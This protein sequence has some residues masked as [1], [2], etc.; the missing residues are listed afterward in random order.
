MRH[1]YWEILQGKVETI[2]KTVTAIRKPAE[3][4]NRKTESN[5]LQNSADTAVQE[6]DGRIYVQ[7]TFRETVRLPEVTVE[8]NPPIPK[9]QEINWLSTLLP[10]ITTISISIVMAV[11]MGNTR[12]IIYTLPMT[13]VGLLLTVINYGN[14]KK[15]FRKTEAEA[16]GYLEDTE[17]KLKQ[18]QRKQRQILQEYNPKPEDCMRMV[19]GRRMES[20]WVRQ[21]KDPDFG[22]AKI[23]RGTI[24]GSYSVTVTGSESM[25]E[26]NLL[27][28]KARELKKKYSQVPEAPVICNFF[29]PFVCGIAGSRKSTDKFLHNVLIQLSASHCYT[30]LQVVVIGAQAHAD[31]FSWT[32]DLPHTQDGSLVSLK[33]ESTDNLQQLLSEYLKERAS[34]LQEKKSYGSNPVI[35]PRYLVVLLDPALLRKEYELSKYLFREELGVGVLVATEQR[36]LLLPECQQ[37]IQLEGD[38]GVIYHKSNSSHKQ[39]F[40]MDTV[41]TFDFAEFGRLMKPLAVKQNE[42][43]A[44]LPT[45][46]T[47]Y[48]MLGISGAHQLDLKQRWTESNVLR[49]MRVPVGITGK[50]K[51]MTLDVRAEGPHG[52]V[53]GFTGSGKSE[54]LITYMLAMAAN[55]SPL[56]V[57]FFLIDYKSALPNQLQELPHTVGFVRD[58]D[59]ESL[60]RYLISL[61][62]EIERRKRIFDQVLKEEKTI[63]N[64]I[65]LF[66]SGGV[67]EAIPYL[68][69]IVDEFA[70]LKRDRPEFIKEL[71]SLA[72]IGRSLGV[73]LI[74]ATQLPS[75]VVDEQISGNSRFRI[76]LKQQNAAESQAVIGSSAAAKIKHI[77]RGYLRIDNDEIIPFQSGYSGGADPA[78]PDQTQRSAVIGAIC[79]YCEEAGIAK[80]PNL[81]LPALPKHMPYAD[82]EGPGRDMR[83]L[84]AEVGRYDAPELQ[85]QPPAVLKLSG[86]N[87]LIIGSANSGK[88][89]LLQTMIRSLTRWYTPEEVNLYILDCNSMFLRNY[90]GLPHVGGAVLEDDREKVGNLFRMLVQEIELRKHKISNSGLTSFS[91]YLEAGYRD[92]PH[93]VLMIDNYMILKARYLADEDPLLYIM[94]NGP[95]RGISVI[96]TN[97]QKTGIPHTYEPV[98]SNKIALFCS[99]TNQYHDLFGYTKVR[100]PEISGRFM[101]KVGKALYEGQSYIAFEGERE[102]D[103]YHSVMQLI[104]E[105]VR[106]YPDQKAKQIPAIPEKVT[107]RHLYG[108]NLLDRSGCIALGM[109]YGRVSPVGMDQE[110]QFMLAVVGQSA[111]KKKLVLDALLQDVLQNNVHRP[112]KLL[113]LDT[114]K[115]EYRDLEDMPY[116]DFYGCKA[117][118]IC[119]I[120]EKVAAEAVKRSEHPEGAGAFPLLLVMVNNKK[121]LEV[122]SESKT[123][124]KMYDDI[125]KNYREQGVLFVFADVENANAGYGS[126]EILKRIREERK[127]L[128]SEQPKDCKLFDISIQQQKAHTN[129]LGDADAYYLYKDTIRRIKLT[130]G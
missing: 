9:K 10:A 80:R 52:L 92:L 103:R 42:A 72:L 63:G 13:L 41:T 44:E 120:L 74:L 99:D 129:P 57:N 110:N 73:H 70:E 105:S 5:F 75:G 78:S 119:A 62:A 39:A 100:L 71:V 16:A 45:K 89:N 59:D 98:I 54:L 36:E 87:T 130:A 88:T 109:D 101:T 96:L 85:A 18:L 19:A 7:R 26:Q 97:S 25:Q 102:I 67:A 81:Y 116:T 111:A 122:L 47:F 28:K 115:K 124:M 49:S 32:R 6:D 43:E 34:Q 118:D 65:A 117:D 113:F 94:T 22:C 95:S 107:Q 66:Q 8:I 23:G 126:P 20:L 123:H 68:L 83:E 79:R 2:L 27:L 90:A 91:S 53:A 12:S 46:Y 30:D 86:K 84:C 3:S 125:S 35:L 1:S 51:S 40:H 60:S 24:P 56:D 108:E 17:K 93:I 33:E 4:E 31:A 37:I 69:I 112:V 128:L 50:Q 104:A 114:M 58:I 61:T 11:T 29:Q 64:Y 48:Q 127:A 76:C 77:G 21:Y 106:R 14:S 55:F 82:G 15:Q 121:A 38:D